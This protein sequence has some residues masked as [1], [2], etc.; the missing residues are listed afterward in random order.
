MNSQFEHIEASNYNGFPVI[1]L[2]DVIGFVH[3]A[4][5]NKIKFIFRKDAATKES[6]PTEFFCNINNTVYILKANNFLCLEDY[7]NAIE[8][9]FPGA[10]EYYAAQKSGYDLFEEFKHSQS[11]GG[12]NKELFD[13]AKTAGFV[14]G[15]DTF[16]KK[17]D[18]YKNNKHTEIIDKDIDS[19]VKLY[20]YAKNKGI[21][22][23]NEFEKVY[24]AGY[25]DPS[26]YNEATAK[27]FNSADDFFEAT[28]KGFT[29]PNEYESAKEKKIATKK[30]YDDYLF[31]KSGNIKHYGYDEFQL[32]RLLQEME[33]GKKLTIAQLRA[34]LVTEQEKYKR[35]FKGNDTKLLPVWY[36]QKIA[37][38][39]QLHTFLSDCADVKKFGTYHTKDKTFEI[40]HINK[41]KVYVDA[42]NVAHN[43]AANGKLIP[44]FRNIRMLIQELGGWKFTDITVIADASLRHKA[45]DINELSRIKK[46]ATYLESPSHTSADKFLLDLIHHEKCI[47]ISNDAFTDWQ[48][49]DFWVKQNIDKIR[50][51]FMIKDDKVLFFGIEKHAP[52]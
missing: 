5:T 19:P 27:E 26:L 4:E 6:P 18:T 44:M 37:N 40:F 17:Y 23:Y 24:D 10:E 25:P 43:S 33:N 1:E 12:A 8:K 29:M 13:E 9:K 34:V 38:D 11:S 51:P 45:K 15:F 49:K 28:R 32:L 3:L 36:I 39:E 16:I 35:S 50:V 22:S 20:H 46:L 47:I 31:L 52:K 42:S 41:T 30:E 14:K 2:T 21:K 48:Q 7:F